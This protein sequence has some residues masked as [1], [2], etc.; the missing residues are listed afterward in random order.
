MPN[1]IETL[2]L[3]LLRAVYNATDGQ[4]MQWRSLEGLD[5]PESADAVRYAVT[6]DGSWCGASTASALPML[7]GE[8]LTPTTRS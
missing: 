7:A 8:S 2:A 1:R 4:Q 3:H 5:L 6:G